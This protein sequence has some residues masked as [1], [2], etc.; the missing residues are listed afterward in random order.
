MCTI[1][2]TNTIDNALF[3]QIRHDAKYNPHGLAAVTYDGK[4]YQVIKTHDPESLIHS[5]QFKTFQ[6]VWVHTRNATTWARGI[7]ATHA[8]IQDEYIVMHNGVL[9]SPRAKVHPVDSML[10]CDILKLSDPA[11]VQDVLNSMGETWANV[12][13]IDTKLDKYHVI[14]QVT[15]SLHTD[16]KGNYS[17]NPFADIVNPVG[18]V[19]YEC[20]SV[21]PPA[22]VKPTLVP[23][24]Y[25]ESDD[26]NPFYNAY[27]D[28]LS[29]NPLT[30]QEK[31]AIKSDFR[32]ASGP[33]DFLDLVYDYGFERRSVR[34]SM[35]YDLC[36]SKQRKQ[37][38]AIQR[39]EEAYRKK[40][41]NMKGA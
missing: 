6:R 37:L 21:R 36:N 40:A 25:A 2:T 17:T 29:D 23:S 24:Y 8:F 19:S 20:V 9:S 26:I 30:F 18:H 32:M 41:Y 28:N 7:T 33:D 5:L 13:I 11:N 4:E 22:I 35:F 14:R 3:D 16:G 38:K 34:S 15:G 12:F 1:I 31:S 27:S 10:L 39:A